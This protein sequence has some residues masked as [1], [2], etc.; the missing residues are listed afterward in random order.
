MRLGLCVVALFLSWMHLAAGSR[1]IKGKRQRRISAEGSQA[2]A[3][4]CELCSEVNGCLKCSPKLFILLERNDIRQ[5]GVCLPSCPPGY[6]DARNPDM[7]KCISECGEGWRRLWPPGEGASDHVHPPTLPQGP[8][9]LTPPTGEPASRPLAVTPPVHPITTWCPP[10]PLS[11]HP[12][13]H[14]LTQAPGT[15]PL[16]YCRSLFI[17]PPTPPS[18][19]TTARKPG[20]SETNQQERREASGR[21]RDKAKSPGGT[22]EGRKGQQQPQHQGTAGPV[23]PAGLT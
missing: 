7:N 14:G 12:H 9:P 17:C 4:G 6:F 23:T 2:C 15:S 18:L 19:H 5:V 16:E 10:P 3:K 21:N 8:E 20:A 11:L 13:C 22:E 1:G